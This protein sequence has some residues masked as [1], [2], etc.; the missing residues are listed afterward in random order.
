MDLSAKLKVMRRE[1]G[2]TQ[3]Q[4]CN[5]L[6]LSLS[7]YKKYEL[8]IAEMGSAALLKITHHPRFEKF[9]LWLMT[10]KTCAECGQISPL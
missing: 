5:L 7:S 10:D 2:L 3:T 4:L 8:G 1:E 6:E 9:A